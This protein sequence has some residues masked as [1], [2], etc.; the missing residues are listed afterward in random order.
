M[1]IPPDTYKHKGLRRQMVDRLRQNGITSEAVL[2]AMTDVPRHCFLDSAFDATAYDDRAFPIGCEQTISHPS[3]V[4]MQSQL[5]DVQPGMKVLEIGTGSGYQTAVLCR[6]GARVFTIERQKPLFDR[7]RALL[8]SLRYR[9]R[10]F[11]G[12]GYRGL[13][14]ADFG[15]FDRILVTCGASEIPEPLMAQLKTDGL[16][17][18]PLGEGQQEMLRIAKHGPDKA[19]W[20]IERFGTYSFVPMLG[21]RAMG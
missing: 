5:L 2:Q 16:M 11:L 9:A 3:T 1:I 7:T 19:D 21:G 6:L 4:A 18:I 20:Q 12:D 14:E 17:V 10:C 8:D 15:P 13:T